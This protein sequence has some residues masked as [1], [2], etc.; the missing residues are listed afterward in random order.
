M[1]TL[2]ASVLELLGLKY[3]GWV[4]L[5]IL[6]DRMRVFGRKSAKVAKNYMPLDM[7]PINF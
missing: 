7:G 3:P 2:F 1:S 6:S 4:R 5:V